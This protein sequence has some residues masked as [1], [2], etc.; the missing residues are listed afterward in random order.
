M[1]NEDQVSTNDLLFTAL[2][3]LPFFSGAVLLAGKGHQ[4]FLQFAFFLL[5]AHSVTSLWLAISKRRPRSIDLAGIEFAPFGIGAVWWF[6]LFGFTDGHLL[7]FA[8]IVKGALVLNLGFAIL[9]AFIIPSDR[10]PF[11]A[12]ILLPSAPLFAVAIA[13]TNI[14]FDNAP[15][16][17]HRSPVILKFS[18]FDHFAVTLPLDNKQSEPFVIELPTTPEYKQ[19]ID[20]DLHPGLLHTKWISEVQLTNQFAEMANEDIQILA[21]E[22]ASHF[23]R[24]PLR[25]IRDLPIL[26]SLMLAVLL[27]LLLYMFLSNICP[28]CHK[29]VLSFRST[30]ARCGHKSPLSLNPG[31]RDRLEFRFSLSGANQPEVI[32]RRGVWSTSVFIGERQI[33][34]KKKLKPLEGVLMLQFPVENTAVAVEIQYVGR[35]LSGFRAFADG[36]LIAEKSI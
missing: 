35:M 21:T 3:V 17:H 31:W 33:Q 22:A 1:E 23:Q 6:L 18:N 14:Y 15:T 13:S 8:P 32:V 11:G 16:V 34:P 20:Y 12:L 30:C 10:R 24:D 25:T 9:L 7:T 19:L 26:F 2:L 29:R 27:E 5:L 28:N 36:K 4:A